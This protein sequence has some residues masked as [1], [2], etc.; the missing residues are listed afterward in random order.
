MAESTFFC[1]AVGAATAVAV[2]VSM[3]MLAPGWLTVL[4]PAGRYFGLRADAATVQPK[5]GERP[6]A[7]A[8]R[9]EQSGDR[10]KVIFELSA[11]LDVTAFVLA[12]PDRV[13]VDLPQTDFALDPEAGKAADPRHR[14]TG[15][16]ASFRFGQLAPGKSRIVVDLG[17][18]ALVLRAACDKLDSDGHAGLVIELA[19]TDRRSFQAAVQRARIQLAALAQ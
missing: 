6:A 9:I 18:P 17:A 4:P 8:A 15:L 12:D 14:K 3:A 19:K 16:I 2:E 10:A 5:P 7:N 13:I 1:K 11:P